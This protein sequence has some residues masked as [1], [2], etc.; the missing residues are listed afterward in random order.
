MCRLLNG[1]LCFS[2]G[3]KIPAETWKY[4]DWLCSN[5]FS[6]TSIVIHR[7]FAGIVYHFSF[8]Y[9]FIFILLSFYFVLFWF[10]QFKFYFIIIWSFLNGRVDGI[11]F[12]KQIIINMII[13]VLLYI[14]VYNSYYSI[15]MV[16]IFLMMMMLM[17][18]M[19]LT[20]MITITTSME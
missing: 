15:L 11:C 14:L 12:P 16:N 5:S 3:I 6:N 18:M 2:L 13:Y 17:M 20:V 19:I 1:L 7:S 4:I 10:I 9:Q 8:C